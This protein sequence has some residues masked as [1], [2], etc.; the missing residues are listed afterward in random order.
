[1]GI[2]KVLVST[3]VILIVIYIFGIS[4]CSNEGGKIGLVNEEDSYL[5]VTVGSWWKYVDSDYPEYAKEI[6]VITGTK[7]LENGKIVMVAETSEDQGYL[8]QGSND[9]I[10]F[11]EK[12]DD[13]EGELVYNP[14]LKIGATWQSNNGSAR[15]VAKEVVETPAGMFE[16]CYRIDAT[17][18]HAGYYDYYYDEYIEYSDNYAVWLAQG[19]GPV[20]IAEIGS[21][22][23]KIKNVVVL[24]SY[25]IAE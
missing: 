19:V 16:D 10:L 17:V 22:S 1:M 7:R 6:I 25:Q 15:V 13:L 4:G 21:D 20:K 5:P 12:L 2:E 14:P 3:F 23:Q 18:A 8:S 9:M 24:D 11:H